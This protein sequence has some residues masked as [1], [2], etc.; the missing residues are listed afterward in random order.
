MVL[1]NRGKYLRYFTASSSPLRGNPTQ[2]SRGN[3]GVQCPHTALC[4]AILSPLC[5]SPPL[6]PRSFS[7][8]RRCATMLP[9]HRETW[10]YC[11]VRAHPSGGF[12]VEIRFHGMRLGLKNFETTNEATRPYDTAAWRLRWPHRTL[13]FPNKSTRNASTVRTQVVARGLALR[14]AFP[15]PGRVLRRAW[16]APA[17]R[18]RPR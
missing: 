5:A 13:N 14:S 17:S 11:G 10:G 8:R 12:S 18:R 1:K 6:P 4:L 3:S 16:R 9:H 7:P 15:T 2:C